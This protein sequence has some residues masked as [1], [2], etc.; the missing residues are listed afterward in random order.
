MEG[1]YIAPEE[2]PEPKKDNT[3]LIIL[4]VIVGLIL[5][6]CCCLVVVFFGLGISGPVIGNVFSNIIETLEVTPLP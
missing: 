5:I 3:L 2:T 4:A 6:C 1:S